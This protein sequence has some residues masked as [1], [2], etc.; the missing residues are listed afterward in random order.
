[1]AIIPMRVVGFGQKERFIIFQ[2]VKEIASSIN[3][4]L[5]DEIECWLM[6]LLLENI[7]QLVFD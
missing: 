1:M 5:I 4:F 2:L 6:S 3:D 7:F